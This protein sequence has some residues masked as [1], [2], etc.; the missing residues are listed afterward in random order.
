M[1]VTP[2]SLFP[3]IQPTRSGMLAVDELH[4]IYWEE[5]GNPDGIPVIFLH[6]GPGAGL[7]P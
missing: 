3:P 1:P 6:G 5:V 7:S 4:T 2:S